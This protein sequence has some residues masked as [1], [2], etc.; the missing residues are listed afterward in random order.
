VN[1][2]QRVAFNTTVQLL[3]R[4][5]AIALALVSFGLVTRYLGVEGFGEYALVLAFLALLVPISDLGLT[6]IGVREL[7]A[8]RD[9]EE[10]LIG[11]LLGLRIAVALIASVLLVAVSPLFP[12]SNQVESGLRLAAVGLF[13]LVL[14]GLPL[15]VFQSRERLELS[16]LLDFVTAA[17]TLLFVIVAT[18]A[19]LG[20]NALIL[21]TVLA[22]FVSVVVG[23]GFG[24]RL[25]RMRPRFD[26]PRAKILLGAAL[27]VGVFLMFSVAQL[28]IDTVM[29]S[30][31]KPVE[32]VGVY[33][34]A[35]RFLEQALFFPGLFMAAVYPILATLIAN[36]DP[37]LQV[38]IDKSLTF[39]LAT[40]IP[41]AAGAFVLAP[42]I[43][44]LLAGED[45]TESVEPMRI[46]VFAA[47]FAFTTALFSSLLVLLARQRQLLVLV[48]AAFALNVVLN[49]ILIPP[50]SYVGAASASVATQAFFGMSL[51]IAA[52]RQ[53]HLSLHLA[54][55]P[56]IVL[57]TAGMCGVLWLTSP[58]P[59]GVTVIAGLVSLAA[60][61]YLL[62]I[63][64]RADI[65]LLR[66]RRASVSQL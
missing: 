37:G 22:G 18:Q 4:L 55:L 2:P 61:S 29:L 21:A 56:R 52:L 30:L 32:D 17:A 10:T 50:F 33:G 59:F 49:L 60:M 51:A 14:S 48:V 47:V 41:L 45:F 16:A 26:R 44:R 63:V 53:G 12:Y 46:L 27:P 35:Y 25:V 34:A 9:E 58:L 23:F 1:I 62:G 11:D 24:S 36:R 28:R 3:A 31:L 20:F 65:D 8:H 38:A 66:G 6:A 64:T 57:A 43:I 19:D 54:Q 13:A 7:A 5:G 42:D 15:I 40:A 39:L